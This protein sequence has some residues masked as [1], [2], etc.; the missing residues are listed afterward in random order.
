VILSENGV[1]AS[2]RVNQEREYPGRPVGT[3]FVN[4]DFELIG[5]AF[6]FGVTRIRAVS[7][8]DELL[9]ALARPGPDFVVV[10][11][12]VKAVLPKTGAGTGAAAAKPKTE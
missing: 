6:G 8:L 1:Y 10:D 3:G 2:I 4:P 11:T 9:A 7:E 12:S 5:R